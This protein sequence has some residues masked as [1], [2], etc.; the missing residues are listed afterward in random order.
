MP[1]LQRFNLLH[2]VDPN[3][4]GKDE[5]ELVEVFRDRGGLSFAAKEAAA[6]VEDRVAPETSYPSSTR[7]E[8]YHEMEAKSR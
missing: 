2:V 3:D 8:D 5:P 4:S 6:F 7:K 1:F